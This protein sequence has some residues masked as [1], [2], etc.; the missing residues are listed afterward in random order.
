[1]NII[2]TT[3]LNEARKEA[4]KLRKEAKPIVILSQDDEFNRKALEI[5]NLKML[6]I[7]ETLE[8]KDYSKQRNS[9][10]NEVLAN[11]CADKKI[12]IGI[13]IDKIINKNNVEKARSLARLAQNIMLCKKAGTRLVFISASKDRLALQS[14]LLS[15]GASTKQAF[16]STKEGF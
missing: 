15:L 3:N 2:T 7:N 5:K 16:E 14:V 6:V 9:G 4:D 10:L 11:I 8:V 12:E 1:M 13:E